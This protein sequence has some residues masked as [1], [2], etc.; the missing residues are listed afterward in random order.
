MKSKK[1]NRQIAQINQKN[2]CNLP[3]DKNS[4]KCSI[5]GG[6]EICA[7]CTKTPERSAMGRGAAC[8]GLLDDLVIYLFGFLHLYYTV[9]VLKCQ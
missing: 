1:L 2:L 4:K 8:L 5:L 6:N 3:L 7:N 9:V